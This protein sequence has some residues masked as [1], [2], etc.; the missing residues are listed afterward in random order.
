MAGTF[1]W[2]LRRSM[3]GQE[4]NED[5]VEVLRALL[6]HGL[7]WL[8]EHKENPYFY[9]GLL[10]NSAP[11][12]KAV[13]EEEGMWLPDYQLV[14]AVADGPLAENPSL[15]DDVKISIQIAPDFR[16][17]AL[18]LMRIDYVRPKEDS[19]ED[20]ADDLDAIAAMH[21]ATLKSAKLY[22]IEHADEE[23]GFVQQ[24]L[25]KN[26]LRLTYALKPELW[27][28]SL[29]RGLLAALPGQLGPSARRI[30]LRTFS[31]EHLEASRAIVRSLDFNWEEAPWQRWMVSL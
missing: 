20:F 7:D 8:E 29:E 23:I 5:E 15:P 21:R 9:F 30:R 18:Q 4:P 3:I 27:G 16:D 13:L 14:Q 24:H 11:A 22:L 6:N 28:S 12:I 19:E 26:E 1:D 17:R 10:S 25:W 31:S 2:A